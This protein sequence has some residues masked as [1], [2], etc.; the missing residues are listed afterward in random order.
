M[1]IFAPIGLQL[2]DQFL[3]LIWAISIALFVAAYGGPRWACI[4]VAVIADLPRELVDQ[5]P[6][7]ADSDFYID[8]AFFGFG[9]WMAYAAVR[10]GRGRADSR[11][12][13]PRFAAVIGAALVV[14]ITGAAYAKEVAVQDCQHR[15]EIIRGLWP[16]IDAERQC[17][18]HSRTTGW[19]RIEDYLTSGDLDHR[20]HWRSR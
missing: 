13:Q 1:S 18:V 6:I 2:L 5:W 9:G 4:A 12:W 7:R 19:L 8:L 20:P 17:W 15:A 16:K 10:L 3:H 14:T 11:N